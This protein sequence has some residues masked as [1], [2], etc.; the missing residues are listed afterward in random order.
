MSEERSVRDLMNDLAEQTARLVR[1]EARLAAREMA[2][3]MRQGRVG[4]GAFGAAG[5]LAFYAGALLLAALVLGLTRAMPSWTA[6]LIVGLGL[7][8][9]AAI[10][11]LI[12]RTSLRRAMPPVPD[13]TIA[14]VREDIDVV[15]G[16]GQN[17]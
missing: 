16:S 15:T 2:G 17:A 12:G 6:A 13:E 1:T 9:P 4:A 8:V 14:R 3:K 7:L 5:V 11:A 10:L